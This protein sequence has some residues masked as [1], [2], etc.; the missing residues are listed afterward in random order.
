MH[1]KTRIHEILEV[2][3]SGDHLS[4]VFDLSILLLIAL[5]VLALVLETVQSIGEPCRGVFRVFEVVSIAV[6]S[7]EYVLRVWSCTADPRYARPLLGRLRFALTP[8]ALIDL[9]A[10]LPFYLPFLGLDLRFVRSVRLLRLFR[11]AKLGRYSKALQTIGHV[12]KAKKAEIVTTLFILCL[13]LLLAS[14]LMYHAEREAQPESFSSI[15]ATMWWS[16][17]TLTTVGYGDTYPVTPLGKLVAAV[18][19]ILGIG[20]FALPTGILGAGFVEEISRKNAEPLQ[21]PFC[22]RTIDGGQEPSA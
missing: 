13:L 15:P 14:C 10:V 5:N 20:M 4:R 2:A 7:C 3:R 22:G 19:A 17:A 9:L 11:L 16:V 18:I 1:V 21:C 6:F 12:L 8:M